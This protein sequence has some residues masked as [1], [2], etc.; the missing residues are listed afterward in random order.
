M[1]SHLS[2]PF[3]LHQNRNDLFSS[4][5]VVCLLY[6]VLVQ[7]FTRAF[8]AA[9]WKNMYFVRNTLDGTISPNANSMLA[10]QF[11]IWPLLILFSLRLVSTILPYYFH[12]MLTATTLQTE[13]KAFVKQQSDSSDWKQ[14]LRSEVRVAARTCPP[15]SVPVRR[16]ELDVEGGVFIVLVVV[17]D[18]NVNGFPVNTRTDAAATGLGLSRTEEAPA[19]MFS[20]I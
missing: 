18:S 1:W 16:L 8:T 3:S 11:D 7:L 10:P 15:V 5:K 6:S 14:E 13:S 19:A 4:A 2:A 9:L 12:L 17:S 20:L